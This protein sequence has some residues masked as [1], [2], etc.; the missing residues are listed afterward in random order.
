M[1]VRAEDH[2]NQH[3]PLFL[4][5][6][7]NLIL[8]SPLA[9]AKLWVRSGSGAG[10]KRGDYFGWRTIVAA[11]GFATVVMFAQSWL[12]HGIISKQIHAYSSDKLL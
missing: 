12:I 7:R 8:A 5:Q 6:L 1:I 11:P 9:D 2:N 4:Q 3:A 10:P